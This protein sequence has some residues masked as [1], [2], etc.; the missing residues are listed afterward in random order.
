M[1]ESTVLA[2]YS[3]GGILESRHAGSVAVAR[4]DGTLV[5]WAGDPDRI[6]YARSAMKPFQAV[7]MVETGAADRFAFTT[8]ELSV[9]CASHNGEERHR[10]VVA[11]MLERMGLPVSALRAGDDEHHDE[12]PTSW[13]ADKQLA[14]NCSGKHAGMLAACLAAG[15]P[16][17]TYDDFE[18]PHQVNIKNLVAEFWQM[19]ADDMIA[20]RDNCTLPAYAAPLRNLAIGW[21]ALADPERGAKAH[22]DVV[23]RVTGAM[24]AEPFMVAGTGRLNTDLMRVTGGRIVAKDGAEGVLCMAL[25]DL[26]LGI[27]F[28]IEDGTF[29]SHQAITLALLEQLDAVND[30][31]LAQL[32]TLWRSDLRSNRDHHVGDVSA[33]F[34]L[35]RPSV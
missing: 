1:T 23:R 9:S 22:A 6:T 17:E 14:Q 11:G 20:G 26:G 7:A 12:P 19:S 24:G 5:A 28:K 2:E 18:H 34:E 29:R 15:Y 35:H 13:D 3:R 10:R 21:A 33:V 4:A 16:I 32:R 8:E 25:T 31:E 30:D 27:S